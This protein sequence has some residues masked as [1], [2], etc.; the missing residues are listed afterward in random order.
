MI[1]AVT[2]SGHGRPYVFSSLRSADA[3]PLVQY[4]DPVITGPDHLRE[5]MLPTECAAVAERLGNLD[6][7]RSLRD[8]TITDFRR[9]GSHARDFWEFLTQVATKPSEDPA[10]VFREIVADRVATRRTGVTHRSTGEMKLAKKH[11][12]HENKVEETVPLDLQEAATPDPMEKLL[13]EVE[14]EE[15]ASTFPSEDASKTRAEKKIPLIP[16]DPKHAQ[17]SIIHLL[18]DKDGKK[19]GPDNNPKK[20]GTASA[21]RFTRYIDG[22]TVEENLKAGIIRGDLSNDSDHGYISIT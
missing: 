10:L 16:R 18:A 21:D 4:G 8:V 20:P 6:T 5:C 15:A 11:A 1:I 7:A 3:H 14:K 17:T 2:R 9:H 13:D 19:Y 12:E 22:G